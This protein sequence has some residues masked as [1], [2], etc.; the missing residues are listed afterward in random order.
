MK[1]WEWINVNKEILISMKSA[2]KNMNEELFKWLSLTWINRYHL[3][4]HWMNFFVSVWHLKNWKFILL[5]D[6]WTE[7]IKSLFN[8]RD[9]NLLFKEYST[10][11]RCILNIKTM[12]DKSEWT[13]KILFC[14]IVSQDHFNLKLKTFLEWKEKDLKIA[15]SESNNFVLLKW[16]L[17]LS[18]SDICYFAFEWITDFYEETILNR[19]H[20]SL[21]KTYKYFMIMEEIWVYKSTLKQALNSY[22]FKED[23]WEEWFLNNSSL[24]ELKKKLMKCWIDYKEWFETYKQLLNFT[25]NHEF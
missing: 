20:N 7:K 23:W 14:S 10:I 1:E 21:E 22:T 3:A 11:N 8:K 18:I 13:E 16:K 9:I 5:K 17:K 12:L 15:L 24:L 19:I 25:I 2:N 4:F 6:Q